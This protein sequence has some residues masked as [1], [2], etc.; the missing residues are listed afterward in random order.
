[1]LGSDLL[2][3]LVGAEMRWLRRL[4]WW[5]K[6]VPRRIRV[7]RCDHEYSIVPKSMARTVQRGNII[8]SEMPDGS[9]VVP[10]NDVV[11]DMAWGM[12]GFRDFKDSSGENLFSAKGLPPADYSMDINGERVKEQKSAPARCGICKDLIFVEVSSL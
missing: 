12:A 6:D 2:G 1:M 8:T 9:N 4:W 3:F 5:L 7:A 10:M 11:N